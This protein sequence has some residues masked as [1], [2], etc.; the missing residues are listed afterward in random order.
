[1]RSMVN[2]KNLDRFIPAHHFKIEGIH[3]LKDVL[4]GGNCLT[5]VH[6]DLN[7][8]YF[9]VLSYSTDRAYL[10]F[11][12]QDHIQPIVRWLSLHQ[13]PEASSNPAEKAGSKGSGIRR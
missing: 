7:D 1:M 6:V 5:K 8:A 9:M 11:S 12:T 13:D 10:H 4:N 3:T 2:L